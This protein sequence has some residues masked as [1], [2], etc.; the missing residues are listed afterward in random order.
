MDQEGTSLAPLDADIRLL[1]GILSDAIRELSGEGELA[2]VDGLRDAALALRE[3]RLEGGRDAFA[4]RFSEL[5][6]DRLA[7]AARAFTQWF[8]LVNAAE[9][10]HRIRVLRQR[11][12]EGHAPE[13]S[14]D[15]AVSQLREAGIDAAQMQ[16]LLGRM[17]VMPVLT[18]HPTEARRRTVLDHLTV[19]ARSLD[20]LDRGRMGSSEQQRVHEAICDAVVALYGTEESRANKPRPA[21]EIRAGLDV[22]GHTLLETTPAL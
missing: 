14:L 17:F 11:D 21:D 22:F 6:L 4:A 12:R 16:A 1:A 2:Y 9:E 18:A 3:G 15:E 13:A 7:L 8:H 10:Q 20:E 19:I 5:D